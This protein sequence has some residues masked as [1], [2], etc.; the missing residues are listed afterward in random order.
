MKYV[1]CS[2]EEQSDRGEASG[3]V[4]MKSFVWLINEILNIAQ[5]CAIALCTKFADITYVY[6]WLH[7]ICAVGVIQMEIQHG[8]ICKLS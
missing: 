8:L 6:H 3:H 5:F 2:C 1:M 4:V 7:A